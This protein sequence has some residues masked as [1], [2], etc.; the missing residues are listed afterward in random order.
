M[1][2]RLSATGSEAHE[3]L[4]GDLAARVLQTLSYADEGLLVHRWGFRGS[5]F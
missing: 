4:D 1:Q 3:T 2:G 5:G